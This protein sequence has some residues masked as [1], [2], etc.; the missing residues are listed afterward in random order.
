MECITCSQPA[1]RQCAQCKEARYCGQ[2]CRKADWP[3][4]RPACRDLARWRAVQD[5]L[6]AMDTPHQ[7]RVLFR[8]T[9]VGNMIVPVNLHLCPID[10]VGDAATSMDG[11][12][13]EN[14]GDG[15]MWTSYKVLA[16]VFHVFGEP[17]NF[18]TRVLVA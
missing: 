18:G 9:R 17:L 5:Y 12:V 13:W 6:H 7:W 11:E 8:H 2:E 3:N 14:Y 10:W 1:D 4:H 16:G 15:V